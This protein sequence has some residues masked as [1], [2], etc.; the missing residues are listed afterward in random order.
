MNYSVPVFAKS[1]SKIMV[2]SSLLFYVESPLKILHGSLE[3]ALGL[4]GAPL[5]TLP[6]P[7]LCIL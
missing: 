3:A 4:V 2:S 1:E 5:A 6:V 7:V